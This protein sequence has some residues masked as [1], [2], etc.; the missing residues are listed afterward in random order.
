MQT[1]GLLFS[2]SRLVM[3]PRADGLAGLLQLGRYNHT[4]AGLSLAEH[5]HGQAIE[6]CFLI[7]GRQSYRVGGQGYNLRG[8]DVFL[9]FPGEVHG[10]GDQPEEKGILYWMILSTLPGP[11]PLLGLPPKDAQALLQALL[12]IRPRHFKG[13]PRMKASLDAFTRLYHAPQGPLSSCAMANQVIAFLLEVVSCAAQGSPRNQVRDLLSVF[14]HI[15]Q[16][17]GEELTVPGLARMCGL[18]TARFKVRFREQAGVPPGEFIQR[19]RVRAAQH[20]L[21]S[22]RYS[23]TEVAMDLGFSSSQYFATVFKRF[24]GSSPSSWLDQEKLRRTENAPSRSRQQRPAGIPAAPRSP[25]NQLSPPTGGAGAAS[26]SP[27]PSLR[28]KGR[29]RQAPAP[30]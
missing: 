25:P 30:P 29:G 18:S 24:T 11:R 17:L 22:G 9:A 14:D 4:A 6:I 27:P 19:E 21:S 3:R 23:V 1:S 13:S 26:K 20:R 5:S 10:S 12:G 8:G 16:N 28:G 2:T 7:K 15:H